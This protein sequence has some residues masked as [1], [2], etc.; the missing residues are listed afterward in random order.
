[1]PM[2]SLPHRNSAM[3]LP[4]PPEEEMHS[5]PGPLYSWRRVSPAGCCSWLLPTV[6][7]T[8][9]W[10][11]QGSPL[12]P[13]SAP[14]R[15]AFSFEVNPRNCTD[16]RDD[17][18]H[19][20]RLRSP[21]FE[22]SDSPGRVHSAAYRRRRSPVMLARA[23]RVMTAHPTVMRDRFSRHRLRQWQVSRRPGGDPPRRK[24]RCRTTLLPVS[25]RAPI[26]ARAWQRP[27]P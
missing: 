2:R 1:M 9:R 11:P 7:P 3:L 5:S 4:C 19:R 15:A 23:K 8:S 6:G 16:V 10:P 22:A 21:D 14:A 13:V 24:R 17:D 26:P 18:Q 12:P 25:A 27:S 20:M